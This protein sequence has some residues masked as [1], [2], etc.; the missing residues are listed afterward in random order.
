[1][2]LVGID[3]NYLQRFKDI[4]LWAKKNVFQKRP[5]LQQL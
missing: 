3:A 5:M 4:A 2:Q 1:M